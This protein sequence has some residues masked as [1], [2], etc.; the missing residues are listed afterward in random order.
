M[1]IVIDG[2]NLIRQS[3]TLR[4]FEKTSLEDGRKALIR[5]IAPYRQEKGHRI[6]I[7]FDGWKTGSPLEERDREGGMDIIYSRRGETADDVIKRIAETSGEEVLV[8][9]ADRAITSFAERR[10]RTVIPSRD[11]ETILLMKSQGGVDGQAVTAEWTDD[12]D[13]D[14]ASR[15]HRKKGPAKR[16]SRRERDY[17]KRVGKL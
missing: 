16:M 15:D 9:T 2:Y 17:R 8:V 10:G 3:V 5:F 13:D 12:D 14:E 1:H 4:R 7:V 6:T 11:F